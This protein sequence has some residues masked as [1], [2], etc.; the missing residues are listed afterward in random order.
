[1]GAV[2]WGRGSATTAPRVAWVDAGKGLAISLVVL[3]HSAR[4]LDGLP[5]DTVVWQTVNDVLATLRLPLFFTLSGFFAAKWLVAPLAQLWNIK[6]RLFVWVLLL[7]SWIDLGPYWL[8]QY[9]HGTGVNIRRELWD[10]ALSP[11]IP[12]FELWFVWALALFFLI[13]RA[14]RRVPPAAIVVVAA[15]AS[16][17]GFLD[18]LPIPSP[19]WTG[20]LKYYVFFAVGTHFRVL[21]F[22]YASR[23]GWVLRTLVIAVWAGCAIAV[24]HLGMQTVPGVMPILGVMGV[25]AGIAISQVLQRFTFVARLGARTLPVYLAHTAVIIMISSVVLLPGAEAVLAVMSPVYPPIV[26]VAAIVASLALHRATA[27]TPLRA[28]FEP[29]RRFAVAHRTRPGPPGSRRSEGEASPT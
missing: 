8:G 27:S 9:L 21:V 11:L 29:P 10:T 13:N 14:L 3:F 24:V 4:W 22:A 16:V 17:V 28:L 1:M 19:G 6:L 5:S 18:I 12:R 26:A 15:G 23:S 25:L 7:W 20:L 2:F